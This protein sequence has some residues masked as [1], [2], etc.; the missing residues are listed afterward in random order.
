MRL[1]ALLAALVL[2]ACGNVCD[3]GASIAS[4]FPEKTQPCFTSTSRPSLSFDRMKCD[5]SLDK[6]TS[7]DLSNIN[8][9]F[10]CL[11]KL[12]ACKPESTADFSAAFL[13]CTGPMLQLSD[14]CFTQ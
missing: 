4:T 9:Y 5:Q 11:D 10:D 1:L 12:P 14:G 8:K 13:A 3:R 7:K 6:C 2:T